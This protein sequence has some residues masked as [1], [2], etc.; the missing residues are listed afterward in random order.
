MPKMSRRQAIKIVAG[1]L[2]AATGSC[3]PCPGPGPLTPETPKWKRD[4][5]QWWDERR[6]QREKEKEDARARGEHRGRVAVPRPYL[7]CTSAFGP[8][9]RNLQLNQPANVSFTIVN[10]GNAPSWSCYVELYEGPGYTYQ[11]RLSEYR[12]TGRKVVTIHPGQ[13]REVTLP[14]QP[15]RAT[16]GRILGVVYDP[17]F[18]PRS[19]D[20]VVQRNR[21]LTAVD[22]RRWGG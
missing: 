10:D 13:T 19:F 8:Q 22:W 4:A 14:W 16:N 21:Q 7:R 2:V 6:R 20:V 11:A 3:G 9:V 12:L 17:M 15:T 5:G 18:D 1:T